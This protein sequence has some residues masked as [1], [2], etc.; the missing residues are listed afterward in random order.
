M[1]AGALASGS[2]TQPYLPFHHRE[3]EQFVLRI[4]P[5]SYQEGSPARGQLEF[6]VSQCKGK[7]EEDVEQCCPMEN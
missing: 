3:A 1:W 6:L 2:Q 4:P 7:L 5:C